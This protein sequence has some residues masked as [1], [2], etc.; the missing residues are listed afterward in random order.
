MLV[1]TADLTIII[2]LF[3]VRLKHHAEGNS[4]FTESSSS[5]NFTTSDTDSSCEVIL[6]IE[7]RKTRGD[8]TAW[9]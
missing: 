1:T 5:L 9:R 6:L 3:D 4:E 7:V 2:H 8:V